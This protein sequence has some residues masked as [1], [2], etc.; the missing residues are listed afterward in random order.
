MATSSGR[1]GLIPAVGRYVG[2]TKN[3]A[4]SLLA[5][6]VLGAQIGVGLGSL[7]PVAVAGCYAI[8]ALVAP[9]ERLRLTL[10]GAGDEVAVLRRDLGALR[11]QV[12]AM[13]ARLEDDVAT[14]VGRLLGTLGSVLDRAE[15]LATAPDQL[16]VVS[17]TIRDY[18]PTS[19][20]SYLNLPRTYALQSRVAG[21]RTAHDELMAQLALLQG[22][23]AKVAQ[24]VYAGDEQA[25]IDQG[26]FLQ[27]KFG[28]SDLD[29]GS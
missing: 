23:L 18:L 16:F 12:D 26:R 7:W 22:E 24:A 11:Q 14:A 21:R 28:G 10:G 17:R 2:S 3:I 1:G 25:L 27:E 29:L 6:T 4:G 19:L 8:G 13:G 15:V 9:P 20:E 5:L